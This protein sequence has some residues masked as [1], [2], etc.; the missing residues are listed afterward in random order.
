MAIMAG[1][2][3]PYYYFY[4]PLGGLYVLWPGGNMFD[5]THLQTGQLAASPHIIVQILPSNSSLSRWFNIK[6]I[7]LVIGQPLPSQV[8][9][10][11]LFELPINGVPYLG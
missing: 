8:R 3:A 10:Y 4:H 11:I 9:T 5:V 7:L 6:Q 2:F 1:P